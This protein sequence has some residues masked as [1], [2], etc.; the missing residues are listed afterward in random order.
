LM[1]SKNALS[2]QAGLGKEANIQVDFP[3]TV[4]FYELI[5]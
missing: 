5:Y 2:P 3:K 1:I 4:L